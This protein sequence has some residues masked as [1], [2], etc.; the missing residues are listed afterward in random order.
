MR[1]VWS[2]SKR[3]EAIEKG[4]HPERSIEF[5]EFDAQSKDAIQN[6]YR[7]TQ[8]A[9]FDCVLNRKIQ[10]SAQDAEIT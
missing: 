9:S 6:Q 1:P 10:H 5:F 7:L 8:S 4:K 3:C 2:R